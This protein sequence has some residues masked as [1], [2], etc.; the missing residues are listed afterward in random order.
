[1]QAIS[2][3]RAAGLALSVAAL[4]VAVGAGCECLAAEPAAARCTPPPVTPQGGGEKSCAHLTD[5]DRTALA[6]LTAVERDGKLRYH[7]RPGDLSRKQVAAA[8][9][10]NGADFAALERAL[11]LEFPR[12]V[13]VFLYRDGADML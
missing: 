2:S 3:R 5:L 7:H 10:A 12:H 8:V 13:H 1:M 6:R 11:A 9:A 4:V